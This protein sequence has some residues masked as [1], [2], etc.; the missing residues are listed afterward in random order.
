[1]ITL[2]QETLYFTLVAVAM[3]AIVLLLLSRPWL[4]Q[5]SQTGVDQRAFNIQVYRDQLAEL[6]T[7]MKE[8]RLSQEQYDQ[9]RRDL[10]RSMIDD[11]GRPGASVPLPPIEKT[12]NAGI[13]ALVVIAIGLPIL[14]AVFYGVLH[15]SIAAMAPDAPEQANATDARGNNAAP[16]AAPGGADFSPD[17]MVNRL[18]ARLEANPDDATGWAM[19]GRSYTVLERL[20]DSRDAYGRWYKLSSG[21]L[22]SEDSA[23]VASYA[24]AISRAND[25]TIDDQVIALMEQALELDPKNQKALWFGGMGAFRSGNYQLA[26]ERWQT[27]QRLIP[28][29]SAIAQPLAGAIEEARVRSGDLQVVPEQTEAETPEQPDPGDAAREPVTQSGPGGQPG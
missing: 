12:A 11:I 24:E 17:E 4:R 5:A 1:M 26:S 20:S 15:F 14:A 18:A 28:A 25:N 19:L 13:W 29:G 10:E 6:E 27:L 2:S 8:Q 7:D 21:R 22:T 3:T 23:L 9:T 16:A